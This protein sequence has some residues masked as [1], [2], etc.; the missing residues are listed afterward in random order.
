MEESACIHKKEREEKINLQRKGL[1]SAVEK[2]KVEQNRAL[3][4]LI[5]NRNGREKWRDGRKK[6]FLLLLLLKVGFYR[7]LGE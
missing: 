6:F 7:H 2:K 3:S 1:F 5:N 4:S